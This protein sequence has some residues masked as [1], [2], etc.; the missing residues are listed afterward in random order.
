MIVINLVTAKAALKFEL[1]FNKTMIV[2][3]FVT[4][5]APKAAAKHEL[6]PTNCP[7]QPTFIRHTPPG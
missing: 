1:L 6:F 2:I 3:N 7:R 5:K 4:P